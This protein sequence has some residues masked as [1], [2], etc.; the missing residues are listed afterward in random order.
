MTAS[1]KKNPLVSSGFSF[2][3]GAKLQPSNKGKQELNK[4]NVF[5]HFS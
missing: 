1:K 5:K 4:V 2:V 3:A